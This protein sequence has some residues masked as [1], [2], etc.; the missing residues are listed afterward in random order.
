VAV[1][2]DGKVDESLMGELARWVERL[3][4]FARP[5]FVRVVKGEMVITG[6]N[7]QLKHVVRKEGVDPEK[8]GQDELWWLKGREYVRFG[9]KEWEDVRG[10]VMKL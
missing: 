7:K 9:K 2:L 4:R 8:V 1:V 6:T 10:G 3:P 5:V